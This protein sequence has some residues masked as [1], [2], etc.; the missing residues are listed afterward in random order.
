MKS[1]KNE[2]DRMSKSESLNY[3]RRLTQ[4]EMT[5]T[6]ILEALVEIK[7]AI[8]ELRNE[9]KDLRNELKEVRVELKSDIQ[10]LDNRLWSLT[11]TMFAGF[12]TLLTGILGIMAHGFGW[13]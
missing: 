13:I 12:G 8:K 5:Q 2:G 11:F 1:H 3:E 4:V 10:R 9:I 7:S 6:H